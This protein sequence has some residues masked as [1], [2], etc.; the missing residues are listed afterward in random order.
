MDRVSGIDVDR[1]WTLAPRTE[2]PQLGT[3]DLL[4]LI[5]SGDLRFHLID[6]KVSRISVPI[7]GKLNGRKSLLQLLGG[8]SVLSW[9]GVGPR[10]PVEAFHVPPDEGPI[11]VGHSKHDENSRMNPQ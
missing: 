5:L 1:G 8:H 10:V 6:S 2:H 3:F 11:P 4:L 9:G 7:L